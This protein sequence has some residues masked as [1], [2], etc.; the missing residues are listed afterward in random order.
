MCSIIGKANYHSGNP[1]GE[2][3]LLLK[4]CQLKQVWFLGINRKLSCKQKWTCV[5]LTFILFVV[6]I[7]MV[8]FYMLKALLVELESVEFVKS[9]KLFNSVVIIIVAVVLVYVSAIQSY[10]YVLI[11]IIMLCHAFMLFLSL[12]NAFLL[13][14]KKI[15][16]LLDCRLP[17]YPAETLLPL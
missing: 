14:K 7:Y 9:R 13:K 15:H 10:H 2:P 5:C 12:R 16:S 6:M 3:H 11:H 17:S 1:H 4:L 8:L